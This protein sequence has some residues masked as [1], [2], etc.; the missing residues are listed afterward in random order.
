[1]DNTIVGK[2]AAQEEVQ[3]QQGRDHPAALES[4]LTHA[5]RKDILSNFDEPLSPLREEVRRLMEAVTNLCQ[6][7]IVLET[8]RS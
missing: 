3:S 5:L 6:R 2:L 8:S 4:V 1:M 7:T